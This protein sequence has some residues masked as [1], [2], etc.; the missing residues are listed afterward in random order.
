LHSKILGDAKKH[1]INLE[2]CPELPPD[3][4]K[5]FAFMAA[6]RNRQ[7]RRQAVTIRVVPDCLT[8][9]KAL[10]KGYTGITA[11]PLIALS[12]L[13]VFPRTT[14]CTTLCTTLYCHIQ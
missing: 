10:G 12:L 2:D 4:L 5:E 14:L 1:P 13:W 6:E 11:D 7:R 9:Y 3:A 8:K